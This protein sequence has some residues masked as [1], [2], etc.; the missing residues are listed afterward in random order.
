[1][2]YKPKKRFDQEKWGE[3]MFAKLVDI[4]LEGGNHWRSAPER[5]ATKRSQ[6]GAVNFTHASLSGA[7]SIDLYIGS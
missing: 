4:T 5:W 1:M 2:I 3:V 6:P 7:S